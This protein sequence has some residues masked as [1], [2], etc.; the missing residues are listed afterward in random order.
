MHPP[1]C[2][3]DLLINLICQTIE[4]PKIIAIENVQIRVFAA[5]REQIVGSQVSVDD[6]ARRQSIETAQGSRG[7]KKDSSKSNCQGNLMA[8]GGGN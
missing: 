1:C 3:W 5:N 8:S 7:S 4:F 2:P 6:P